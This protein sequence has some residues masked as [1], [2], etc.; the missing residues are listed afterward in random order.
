MK[1][2]SKGL[3]ALIK[4]EGLRHNMYKD[5][6]GYP[7]I[8]VGHLLT[9]AEL[10]TGSIMLGGTAVSWEKGLTPAQV[11]D[12][13]SQDLKKFENAVDTSVR[14]LLNQNQ[15][16]ALVSF[17]FNVGV[18]AFGRSTLL[19]RLNAALPKEDV[20]KEFAKWNRAGGKVVK[21]LVNRRKAE[22]ALFLS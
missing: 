2:S 12:L 10:D 4:H 5:V 8:G 22:A 17:A 6:A 9:R 15:F 13:L 1:V 20:A 18:G 19:K 7:T 11:K 14:V 16:D 3:D 21:G